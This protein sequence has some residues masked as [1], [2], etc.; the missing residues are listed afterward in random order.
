MPV[1]WSPEGEQMKTRLYHPVCNGNHVRDLHELFVSKPTLFNAM[2]YEEYE[3][4]EGCVNV[5]VARTEM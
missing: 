3:D 4:E 5:I 2:E 1:L